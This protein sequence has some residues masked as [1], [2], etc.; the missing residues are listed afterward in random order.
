MKK[1]L[2]MG[3]TGSLGQAMIEVFAGKFKVEFSYNENKKLAESLAKKY[4]VK[5]IQFRSVDDLSDDYDIVINSTGI[6]KSFVKTE[7]VKVED[8]N[9]EIEVNLTLPFLVIKKALPYMKSK[10]WGRIINISSIYGIQAE[11]ELLPYNVSKNGVLALTRTVAKEYGEYGITC[12]AICPGTMKSE[13]TERV[14]DLFTKS[15]ADKKKY[16]KE[17]ISNIPAK[18]LGEPKEIAKIALFLADAAY[19]NGATIVADGGAIC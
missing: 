9:K 19:V 15:E 11:E 1:V 5:A 6:I 8:W 14:A 18:R 2:I 16:Y 12:N 4:K 17:M 7:K 10:K 3:G 13:M